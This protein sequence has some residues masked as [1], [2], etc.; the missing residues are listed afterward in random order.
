MFN[1]RGLKYC[2]HQYFGSYIYSDLQIR[3]FPISADL[4]RSLFCA[5]VHSWEA[6]NEEMEDLLLSSWFIIGSLPEFREAEAVSA[7][8]CL[9][10]STGNLQFTYFPVYK[11]TVAHRVA[12]LFL[13]HATKYWLIGLVFNRMDWGSQKLAGE[14][15]EV[16]QWIYSHDRATRSRIR[17]QLGRW[18]EDIVSRGDRA[19]GS[20]IQ[21][22]LKV[23]NSLTGR[24]RSH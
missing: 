10:V 5:L 4:Y 7:T 12:L 20:H 6:H 15:M 17:R 16:L 18:L 13:L 24:C 9:S 19:K 11:N 2:C 8:S 3:D 23:S 14:S 22:A 21:M 1:R